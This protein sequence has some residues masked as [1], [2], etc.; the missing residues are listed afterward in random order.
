MNAFKGSG[1]PWIWNDTELQKIHCTCKE[2]GAGP[3]AGEPVCIAGLE[4]GPN[5]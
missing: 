1:D 3:E 5:V 2:E 4:Q